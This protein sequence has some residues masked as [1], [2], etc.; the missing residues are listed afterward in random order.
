MLYSEYIKVRPSAVDRFAVTASR[1]V[2]RGAAWSGGWRT[3]RRNRLPR[4]M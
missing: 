4:R 2:F 1:G 3:S